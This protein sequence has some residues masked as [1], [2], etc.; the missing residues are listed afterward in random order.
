MIILKGFERYMTI[1]YIISQL[2]VII[3]YMFLAFSYKGK[4]TKQI[5]IFNFSSLLA[6]AIAYLFLSAWSGFVMIIVSIIRNTLFLIQ[7]KYNTSQNKKFNFLVL[8]FIISIT[9]VL[10]AFTYDG[11]FSM[12]PVFATLLY[13][14]SIWQKNPLTYKFLGIPVGLLCF[15]YE[16]HILSIFGMIL[17][18]ALLLIVIIEIIINMKMKKQSYSLTMQK[19]KPK[20]DKSIMQLY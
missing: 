20:M 11:L 12:L 3:S 10:A 15:F 13:T 17:E 19:N 8:S 14:Y 7:N 9:I 2:F 18:F 5:I 6:T 4:N 16:I 1:T